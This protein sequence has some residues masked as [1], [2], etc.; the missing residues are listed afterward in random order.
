MTI[1]LDILVIT[2]VTVIITAVILYI[3]VAKRKFNKIE[4]CYGF[5]ETP[6]PKDHDSAKS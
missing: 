2:V 1:P 3:I 5:E 4:D 6:E